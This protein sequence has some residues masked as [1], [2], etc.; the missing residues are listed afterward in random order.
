MLTHEELL[1]AI[2]DALAAVELDEAWG[3]RQAG[4]VRDT[5]RR[6]GQLALITTDRISAFDRVLGLI[7]YKGQVLNQLSAWW[8][9]QTAGIA[10]NHVI[11]VPDPNVTLAREAQ[12]LP[13]EVVVRGYITGVT[14]TSL[15][16]L[17]ERGERRPYG[18]ALP[19]GLRKND[20]LPQPVITPTTK[21]A[22]GGHDRVLTSEAVVAEGWVAPEVWAQV[23]RAALALFAE[24]QRVA[25]AAGLVLVDT[26]YEFGLVD[27]RLTVIDEMHTPDSSRYWSA[28]SAGTDAPVHYDKEFL[29]QWYAAR[30]YRGDGPP[31]A[32]PDDFIAQVAARY[33]AAYERLTGA[34][35]VPG[36][37]PAAARIARALRATGQN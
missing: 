7:P 32:M 8:F 37:M 10:S 11:A 5:Y 24:G 4:K 15:W 17:Y 27:G 35:F 23:E 2:P 22:D 1:A 21:A 6:D 20:P 12:P 16:Y 33:I 28:E 34:P 3:P 13:V 9:K 19:E 29:R 14:T 30:G 26:K 25:R 31:P 36:E 18:V